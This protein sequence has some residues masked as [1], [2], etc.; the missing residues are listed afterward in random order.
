MT[1]AAR[2]ERDALIAAI[3]TFLAGHDAAMLEEIRGALERELDASGAAALAALGA[4]L[5]NAGAD[6]TFYPADPLARR[7]HHLLADRLLGS[8]S[9]LDGVEHLHAVAG[10]PVVI[11]ANHLSYSDANV[12]EVLLHG[13]G[14]EALADRLT[15]MAGP[16]VYSSVKRRFSSLCFGTIKTPQNS[17]RSSED[18]VMNARDVARAA[19]RS[20]E[21]AHERLGRGDALLV[22]AEGTR[23]RTG[24][25]QPLLAGA[26]RYCEMP[27]TWLLPVGITGSDAMFP[28]GEDGLYPVRVNARLGAP[29]DAAA[30]HQ[31][32]GGDRRVMMDHLGF[33]IAELLPP[34]YRGAYA[35]DDRR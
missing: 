33:A 1:T 21:I 3:T 15:V 9:G 20:I 11:L 7:V 6:W 29:I 10:M 13:G 27:G 35:D 34:E 23:S 28:I 26:A 25:M 24:G 17:A 32:V 22:F 30:L 4:R 2:L 14:G 31:R 5:A 16:K 19:R 18:A 8:G 12:L